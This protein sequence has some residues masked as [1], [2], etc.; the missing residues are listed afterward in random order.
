MGA[1]SPSWFVV[2]ARR[3]KLEEDPPISYYSL[4]VKA[5]GDQLWP[6]TYGSREQLQAFLKGFS[7]AL[8]MAGYAAIGISWDIPEQW[9]EPTG[10]RWTIPRM[11]AMPQVEQLDSEGQVVEI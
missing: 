3:K 8:Y 11:G 9:S 7:C 4:Q 1:D 6:E 2:E 5:D 10:L